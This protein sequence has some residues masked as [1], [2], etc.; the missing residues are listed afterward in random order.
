ML[1]EIFALFRPLDTGSTRVPAT[2]GRAHAPSQEEV[3]DVFRDHSRAAGGSALHLNPVLTLG[4]SNG[5]A[6]TLTCWPREATHQRSESARRL[7]SSQHARWT[8]R[9]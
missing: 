8:A 5:C 9:R 1:D 3:S 6:N 7:A 2:I 4:S